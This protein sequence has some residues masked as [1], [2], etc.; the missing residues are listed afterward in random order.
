MAP[1]LNIEHLS[2]S[3]G[4]IQAIKDVSIHLEQGEIVSVLGA[5]GAGKSTLLQAV[6]GLVP[7]SGGSVIFS[8]EVLNKVPAYEIVLKGISL[9]PEGRRVFPTLTVEENLNLGAYTRRKMRDEVRK[10]KDRV[11]S[12]FPILSERRKQLAGTLSGG[13]QQMLA[14]GRAL[15]STP[16]VLLLDEPSLGLAPILVKQIFDI[17]AEINAQGTSILLVEQNAHKALGIASR[18]YVLENGRIV[19]SGPTSSLRSDEKIQEAY[20]G[21]AALR[22]KAAR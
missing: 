15:M 9:S 12:L 18:G 6:S 1:L 21:G 16:R 4:G 8:S 10:A 22:K 7:I 20:L 19:A 14:I 11:F 13:E 2:I 3:Y 5:N 17:I